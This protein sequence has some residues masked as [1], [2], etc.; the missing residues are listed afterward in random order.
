MKKLNVEQCKEIQGG[1]NKKQKSCLKN[2]GIQTS[3]G[4]I[5]GVAPGSIAAGALGAGAGA[6]IGANAG[7]IAGSFKC[8]K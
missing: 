3:K 8:A 2:L 1:L 4:V 7:L 6:I 5:K